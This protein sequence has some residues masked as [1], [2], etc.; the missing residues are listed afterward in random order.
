[1]KTY[2]QQSDVP[3][4]HDTCNFITVLNVTQIENILNL[5]IRIMYYHIAKYNF[6]HMKSKSCFLCS[7]PC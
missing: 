3:V 7:F 5:V 1:M 6:C 2:L 4:C